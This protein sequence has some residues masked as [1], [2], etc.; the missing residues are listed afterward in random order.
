MYICMY[1]FGQP[2]V[3]GSVQVKNSTEIVSLEEKVLDAITITSTEALLEE[4]DVFNMLV[5]LQV[6]VYK[7]VSVCVCVNVCSS[8]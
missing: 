1:G 3:C 6:R 2:C 5:T 8:V 7:C 4:C